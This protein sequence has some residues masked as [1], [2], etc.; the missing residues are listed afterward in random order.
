MLL[1]QRD[2]ERQTFAKEVW[3]GFLEEVTFKLK[4][5]EECSR[6]MGDHVQRKP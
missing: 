2:Q 3:G 1:R 5:G 6:Q 4:P